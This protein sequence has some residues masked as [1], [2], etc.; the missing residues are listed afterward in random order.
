MNCNLDKPKYNR[1][2][3]GHW[4]CLLWGTKAT[5]KLCRQ[6]PHGAQEQ[7]QHS[8][9]E[10]VFIVMLSTSKNTQYWVV[11]L[12]RAWVREPD[13]HR[14]LIHFSHKMTILFPQLTYFIKN[15]WDLWSMPSLA[16]HTI[17]GSPIVFLHTI[18]YLL[19]HTFTTLVYLFWLMS[20]KLKEERSH[21]YFLHCCILSPY[22]KYSDRKYGKDL[23]PVVGMNEWLSNAVLV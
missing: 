23:L 19:C 7:S 20:H 18:L 8:A 6:P 12:R 21:V 16:F 2:T 9:R 5:A 4:M 10:H 22:S 1:G 3:V 11:P 15:I 17:V 14:V 13:R